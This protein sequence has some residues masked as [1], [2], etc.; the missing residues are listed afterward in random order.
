MWCCVK[1]PQ[2]LPLATLLAAALNALPLHVEIISA[3]GVVLFANRQD[4]GQTHVTPPTT[5][6]L[7]GCGGARLS[8][9]GSSCPTDAHAAVETSAGE[10]YMSVGSVPALTVD[11]FPTLLS[12]SDLPGMAWVAPVDPETSQ[13]P[14]AIVVN[15]RW[16]DFHGTQPGVVS[17]KALGAM[18]HPDDEARTVAVMSRAL[19]AKGEYFIEHR[20]RRAADGAFV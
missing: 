2:P 8:Y 5:F 14:S 20:R 3:A 4:P 10:S 7:A 13:A 15:Q 12:L 11:S 16:A 6:E 17:L 18:L 19:Q 9:W 1:P